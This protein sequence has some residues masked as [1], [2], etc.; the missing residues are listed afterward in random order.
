M[1]TSASYHQA[2]KIICAKYAVG[3]LDL[4]YGANQI[5]YWLEKVSVAFKKKLNRRQKSQEKIKKGAEMKKTDAFRVQSI[6][7]PCAASDF[8]TVIE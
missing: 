6:L 4:F 3:L 7:Q 1:R 8:V 2:W 5:E